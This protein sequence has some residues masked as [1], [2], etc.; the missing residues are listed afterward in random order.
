VVSEE[1]E[2]GQGLIQLDLFRKPEQVVV[3]KLRKMNISTMTPLDA[4]N[5]LSELK[6]KVTEEY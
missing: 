5:C 3:E 2:Q 4:I 1:P 6:E